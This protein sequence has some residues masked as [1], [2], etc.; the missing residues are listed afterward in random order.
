VRELRERLEELEEA[1]T[2]RE[3]GVRERWRGKLEGL[4][5]ELDHESSART[6]CLNEQTEKGR[7]SDG[8]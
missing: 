2:E 8:L 7:E 3:A 6:S 4:K 5:T 1:R